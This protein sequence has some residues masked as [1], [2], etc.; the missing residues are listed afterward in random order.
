MT[1]RFWL[2]LNLIVW[3]LVQGRIVLADG[4]YGLPRVVRLAGKKYI[5]LDA[6]V[7]DLV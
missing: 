6:K 4:H 2:I 3:G 7:A 1:T 5:L